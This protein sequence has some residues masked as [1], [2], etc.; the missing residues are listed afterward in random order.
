MSL[1]IFS[2]KAGPLKFERYRCKAYSLQ[3]AL[4]KFGLTIEDITTK[5]A[6][7]ILLI[8]D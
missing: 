7:D 4:D 5:Y 2:E 3:E 6:V 8:I 1:Y